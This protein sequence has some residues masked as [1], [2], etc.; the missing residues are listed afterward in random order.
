[1]D[2][3]FTPEQEEF[4]KSVVDFAKKE[5]QKGAGDPAALRK[6]DKAGEFYREG[7]DKCAEF[8]LLALPVPTQYGG[9]GK[10]IVDCTIAMQALGRECLDAGLLFSISSHVFTCEI[11]LMLFGSAAQKEKYL[12]RMAR[13]EIIGCHAMTEPEAGSDAF[14]IRTTAER[15]GDRFVLRGSKT[16]TSNAPI[17]DLFLVFATTDRKKGW[18]GV[19]GFLVDRTTPGLSV[20]TPLE[21][22]GL[23][24]SPTGEITLEDVEVP[25]DAVLGKPGQGSAIFNAEMEWERS[26]LFATHLGAMQRQL[27]TCVRY[28][29]TRSQFGKSIASFQ[30]V[31]HKMA[32]MRV[33]IELAELALYK[34]AWLK[35][36]GQRAQMESAI[37]KLFVSES[38]VQSSLDA[39]QIHGGYGFMTEYD[40]ERDLRDA[41]GGKLYSGTSEIQRNII[42]SL[43]G[44]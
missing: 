32:D 19:T 26:C 5:L 14:S 25:A 41:I 39:V 4:R 42:A 30:A 8:G 27:D 1:V 16:F 6:R 17:A 35:A 28:A 22:M 43:L 24:T 7:W 21:K 18:A 3:G 38:F 11:P 2:F 12:P 9:L 34:V 13:G 44:L 15:K 37:S 23:K 33:R 29:K 10:D 31:S 40:V 36:R 20:G